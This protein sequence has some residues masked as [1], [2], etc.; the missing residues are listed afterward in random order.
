MVPKE[1]TMMVWN[2]IILV[3]WE[4]INEYTYVKV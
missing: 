2:S 3:R 1:T 4:Q